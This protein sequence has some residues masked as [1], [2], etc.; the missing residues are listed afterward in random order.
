MRKTLSRPIFG[1]LIAIAITTTMDATGLTMFSALP[2]FPL[3]GIF[4]Y[5]ER[6][7]RRDMGF[8]W[9]QWRHYGLALLYP[10]V[11]LG[12][13][14]IISAATRAVDLS[15][16]DWNK[17]W[18]NLAIVTASTF[19]GT[20]LTEEGFFRG[21]LWASLKRAGVMRPGSILIWTSVAF[22]LWHVSAVTLETGFD[23]P[24]AQVPVFL[25]NA[26]VLGAIWGLLR[27]LSG[28][29]IVASLSHGAWNGITYTLFGYG[30]TVGALG[31]ENTSL[32]GPEV[33]FLGLGLN[34]IF[35]AVLWRWKGR[36][37]NTAP[38]GETS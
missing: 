11:V 28:S 37:G 5:L 12:A 27:W 8:V 34:V 38:A 7:S 13:I 21:W 33:G 15:Q 17:T 29:V 22:S 24:A 14:T 20:I 9:G 6:L 1:V 26:A 2:L 18:L 30:T 10:V 19:V 16:A 36:A 4:W 3:M 32:L 25:V 31:V 35:F 23:L